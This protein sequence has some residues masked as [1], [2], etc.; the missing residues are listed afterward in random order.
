[1]LLCVSSCCFYGIGVSRH[2]SFE[3]GIDRVPELVLNMLADALERRQGGS[4]AGVQQH[5]PERCQYSG[6]A[7]ASPSDIPQPI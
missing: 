1:M 6:V 7:L 5:R 2:A 3:Q 4:E